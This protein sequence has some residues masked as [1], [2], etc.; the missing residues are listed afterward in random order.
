[1]RFCI[2]NSSLGL[3]WDI[4]I[5][6]HSSAAIVIKKQGIGSIIQWKDCTTTVIAVVKDKAATIIAIS[7]LTERKIHNHHWVVS[8]I[9]S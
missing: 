7:S 1:M 9:G 2:F 4:T 8:I 5:G 3:R 6:S